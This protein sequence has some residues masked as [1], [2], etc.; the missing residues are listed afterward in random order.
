M[1][2]ESDQG[3]PS[4]RTGGA[5]NS[6]KKFLGETKGFHGIFHCG[7]SV[8]TKCMLSKEKLLNHVRKKFSASEKRSPEDNKLHVI[9]VKKPAN[10]T[11][12]ECD[13]PTFMRQKE[14]DAEMRCCSEAKAL[15][16]K[17][18]TMCHSVI[19]SQMTRLPQNRVKA[20]PECQLMR[21]TKSSMEHHGENMQHRHHC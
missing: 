9:G 8:D 4:P 1:S 15:I 5:T 2:K 7:N 12:E 21:A 6:L 20:Q 14:W 10:H 11:R 16:T 13:A 17:N 18:P 3:P 19:W